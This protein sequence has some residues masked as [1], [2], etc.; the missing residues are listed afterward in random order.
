MHEAKKD[1][2][3]TLAIVI[4]AIGVVY[5]DIGTSPLYALKSC[6][7]MGRLAVNEQN[8]LGLTSLFVW[9][10][11]L[12]VSIKYVLMVMRVDDQGEGGILVLSSLFAK[13]LDAK[14]KSISIAFGIIGACLFFGDGV[15]T[16]AISILSALEGLS[17]VSHVFSDHIVLLSSIV[18]FFGRIR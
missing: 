11:I 9:A 2:P 10:L 15:I 17:F 16:P 12:I 13:C 4:S 8:I 7:T 3:I 18:I 14:Y 6:F 5:G 1:I